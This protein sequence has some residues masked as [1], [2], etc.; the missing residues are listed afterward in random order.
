MIPSDLLFRS[1]W[2]PWRVARRMETWAEGPLRRRAPALYRGLHCGRFQNLVQPVTSGPLHHF[3]G[4]Y[5]KSPWNLSGDKLLA[6][7]V[8][9]DDRPPTARDQAVVG[10]LLLHEGNRFQALGESLAWNWQ[11]GCMLQ[12]HPADPDTWICHN[13]REGGKFVGLIRN[14]KGTVEARFDR[15]FYAMHP[16]GMGAISLNFSRLHRLRPGYG[17]AGVED[18]WAED[19]LPDGDGLWWMDLQKGSSELILSVKE[20]ARV[21]PRMYP[22]DVPHWVNHVQFSPRGTRFA[23]LHR[24]VHPRRGWATR[25][26]VAEADGTRL[27]PII[28]TGVVSHYD[29]KDEDRLLAWAMGAEGRPAFHLYNVESGESRVVGGHVMQ[30]DGHCNFSPNGRW[31]LNDTYPDPYGMRTLYLYD[32]HGKRRINLDRFL[33]PARYRGE[34]RCDLHPRWKRDG[35]AVCIDST[36]TGS[37]QMYVVNLHPIL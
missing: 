16:D 25:L 31:I 24:W 18:P 34:I 12:W 28:T 29:W 9:F 1:S 19:P 6:L 26:M 10:C 17:Y 13:H 14:L 33:S 23:F 37:R 7:E 3:F 11:Q 36:H 30:E 20:V 15:P 27:R 4:Y 2:V 35:T 8:P 21:E 32:L 22:P 5:D